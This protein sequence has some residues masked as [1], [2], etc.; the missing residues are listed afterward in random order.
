TILGRSAGSAGVRGN[1]SARSPVPAQNTACR[2]TGGNRAVGR[3]RAEIRAGRRLWLRIANHLRLVGVGA[4]AR[5]VCDPQFR[6]RGKKN[7]VRAWGRLGGKWNWTP[8]QV[9]WCP[10]KRGRPPSSYTSV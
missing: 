3:L 8:R 1:C 6:G 5:G 9:D 7:R 2:N 4:G 10:L